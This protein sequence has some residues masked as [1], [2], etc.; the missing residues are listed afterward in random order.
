ME[1]FDELLK[2]GESIDDSLLPYSGPL[3]KGL[4]YAGGTGGSRK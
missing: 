3:Q 1:P 2:T 4:V